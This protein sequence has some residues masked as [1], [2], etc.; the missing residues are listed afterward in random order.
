MNRLLCLGDSITDCGRLFFQ[1]PL[2]NGYVQ[3]LSEKLAS[4]G[5]N[6]QIINCGVDGFTI[7]RLL[8]NVDRRYLPL[9][10]DII[11]I[12]IGI[13]DV[14]LMM[15]TRRTASQQTE[16]LRTFLQNYERLI[17]RLQAPGRRFVLM[18][19]FI[20]PFPAEFQTWQPHVV[21]MSEGIASLAER[22]HL[23]CLSLQPLFDKSAQK[24]GLDFVTTDGVHLTMEGQKILAEAL[25][26][27]LCQF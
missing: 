6:W 11:T 18:K 10:P 26:S 7:S 8:E 23:P 19:P 2:G 22:F 15:N 1:A 27:I 5:E 20:F 4:S 13:N 14:A 17:Q 9:Q 16:M 3:M 24:H 12:L 21:A 25:Y